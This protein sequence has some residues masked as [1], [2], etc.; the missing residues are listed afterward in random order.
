[1]KRIIVTYGIISGIIVAVLMFL[2]MPLWDSGVVNFSNGMVVGY[3]TM[4]V[5]LSLIFFAVRSYRDNFNGGAITFWK[6]VQIGLVITLIASVMYALAWEVCYNTVASD[7]IDNMNEYRLKELTQTG[8][9]PE[10]VEEMK[11]EMAEFGV[12]YRNPIIRFAFSMLEIFPVGL[13]ITL[14]SSGLLRKREFLPS[15]TT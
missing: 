6:G 4:V 1:M 9:S 10:K 15:S 5:A 3:T 13:I 8:A 2:T 12:M 11:T 14:I 7:F